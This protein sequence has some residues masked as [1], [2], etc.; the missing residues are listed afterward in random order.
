MFR[1][2]KS[3]PTTMQ[4]SPAAAVPTLSAKFALRLHS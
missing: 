4:L 1:L 3:D 2:I